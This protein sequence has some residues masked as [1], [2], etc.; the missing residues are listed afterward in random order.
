M[1][2]RAY[3]AL[4]ANLGD[5]RAA[6]R[7]GVDGLAASEGITVVA[8]SR[9]YETAPVGPPQPD[10]LNAVVAIDTTLSPRAL[11]EVAQ[12]LEQAAGRIRNERWG[13]RTL[14]VDILVFGDERVSEPDLEIPHPRMRE[15]PF[16]LAPLADVAP[17]LVW[18][19]V[20]L[21]PND[22]A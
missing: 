14:D 19:G 5:R 18:E 12:S 3:V 21:A 2:V 11:L 4:G 9:I 7:S 6:L 20:R 15:R 16:V 22:P 17:E 10:Y 13:A 1:T 8:M